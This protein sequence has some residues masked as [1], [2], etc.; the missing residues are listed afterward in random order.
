[1]DRLSELFP[2]G[3]PLR[4]DQQ[5]GRQRFIDSI[6]ERLR[7]GDVMIF[8]DAR[9]V[10]KTSVARASLTRIEAIGGTVAEVNL[11]A[12]GSDH[13]GAASALASELA[14]NL[15]RN[16][17]RLG[18]SARRLRKAKAEEAAGKEAALVVSLAA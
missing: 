11:A 1:M 3:P 4:E 13:L 15:R 9:R 17:Q 10:G 2:A 8:A 18:N 5:I 12:H 6:E 14:G 7:G 16:A